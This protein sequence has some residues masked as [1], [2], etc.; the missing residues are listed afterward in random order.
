MRYRTVLASALVLSA[1]A[2]ADDI[3]DALGADAAA[4]AAAPSATSAI[5]KP[6]FTVRSPHCPWTHICQFVANGA[7]VCSLIATCW[8]KSTTFRAIHIWMGKEVDPK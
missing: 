2:F 3:D 1:G 4:S 8:N 7:N 6:Q 5:V